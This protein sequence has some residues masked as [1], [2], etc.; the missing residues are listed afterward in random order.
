MP[1]AVVLSF[2]HGDMCALYVMPGGLVTGT[3]VI[4]NTAEQ[5]AGIYADGTGVTEKDR[6][7]LVSVTVTDNEASSAGGGLY[8]EDGAAMTVN[9]VVWG[10]TAPSDKNVSGVL[11]TPFA[12]AMLSAASGGTIDEF[13]P[14]NNC[15]VETYEIPG[16]FANTS[17]ER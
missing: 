14:M 9:A 13:Y 17:L 8:L 7:H 12:D 3:L 1:A 5:G 4:S 15:F 11:N 10:N 16:N 6:A 2:P